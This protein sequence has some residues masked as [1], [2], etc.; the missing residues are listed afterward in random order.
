MNKDRIGGI[1]FAVVGA[2]V[3][4]MASQI[5]MPANLSEPG[6]R[7]F[8]Y[9]A[10]VG[11][12][13]CGLGMLITAKKTENEK[14]FLTKAGWI[15]LAKVFG[16]LIAY[17]LGLQFLGFLISTPFFTAFVILLLAGEKKVNKISAIVVAVVTTAVI[18]LLF[19]R[20]FSIFLPSG[21]IFY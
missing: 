11:M 12:I 7:L 9:I 1:F 13:L 3:V 14:P 4:F 6:P 8:P 21:M 16:L 5:R 2:I 19:V 17:C 20:V 18:Y 15:K 10:G